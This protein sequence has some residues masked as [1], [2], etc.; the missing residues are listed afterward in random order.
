MNET[1]LQTSAPSG[2]IPAVTYTAEAVETMKREHEKT[3]RALEEQL[4][5]C[6]VG[7]ALDGL[8]AKSGVKNPGFLKKTVDIRAI[9]VDAE[10]NPELSGIVS[11]LAQLKKTDAYLFDA[12]GAQTQTGEGFGQ[13]R[14]PAQTEEDQM[15]DA[16]YYAYR[17]SSR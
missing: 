17:R 15:S 12:P 14:A 1:E 4:H 7:Y 9:P 11:M 10:G 3:V 6:R 16:E 2:D 8:F 13:Y 5:D